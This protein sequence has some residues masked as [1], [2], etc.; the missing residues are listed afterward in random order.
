MSA[1]MLSTKGKVVS[2]PLANISGSAYRVMARNYGA[3]ITYSEMISVDGLL[4][5][6][7]KTLAMLRLRQAERPLAFQLFGHKP[8]LMGEAAKLVQDTGCDII[9]INL[10]CPAKKVVKNDA[11]AG[12]VKDLK[13]VEK[14]ISAVVKATNLIVSVK[15]RLGWDHDRINFLQV[16]KIAEDCGA[17]LLVLH[18][19]TRSDGF[20]GHSDWSKIGELKQHVS[21][22][23]IG[24]GDI[25]CPADAKRML[26]ETGCDMVMV[27]RAAMGA[28]WLFERID[29][30]LR[31]GID[32]G[33][34]D[35][36]DRI[37]IMLKFA[38]LMIED[39]GERSA[40]LKLRKH[41][42]WFTRGWQHASSYRPL[43]FSVTSYDD[44]IE[45]FDRYM[46]NLEKVA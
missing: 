22:P 28:P 23:V 36:P 45:L 3:A 15:F 35:L 37:E 17:S 43:M 24:S 16:G 20:K 7:R 34:P 31:E 27:G 1:K 12:L 25:C 18:P 46:Q 21:L 2:A 29:H 40:C 4:R 6:N 41:L 5:G 10:G 39:Y 42:A 9:D 11:G 30:Y 19:R 33:D 26:A 32:P 44:I 13:L 14:V 8:E 38:R